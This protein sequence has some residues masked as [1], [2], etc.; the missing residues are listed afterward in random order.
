MYMK[1]YE[2]PSN[3]SLDKFTQF[4]FMCSS[5]SWRDKIYATGA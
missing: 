3:A 2:N 5:V 4:L 1:I